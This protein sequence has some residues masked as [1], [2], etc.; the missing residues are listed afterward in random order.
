MDYKTF[1]FM[2]LV[3]SVSACGG[4]GGDGGTASPTPTVVI[5]SSAVADNV[6]MQATSAGTVSTDINNIVPLSIN[7]PS[8]SQTGFNPIDFT[9]QLLHLS[10][11]HLLQPLTVNSCSG[12]GSMTV[13]DNPNATSGTITFNNCNELG[14]TFNGSASFSLSGD[15]NANYSVSITYRNLTLSNGVNMATLNASMNM[16]GSYNSSTDTD[17]IN[18][19]YSNFKFTVNADYISLYN[20]K[21]TGVYNNTTLAYTASLDY[22]FDSSLINGV[23]HVTTENT[24]QGNDNISQYPSSGSLLITG[25]SNTSVR[26]T[27]NSITNVTVAADLNGDGNYEYSRTMLWTDFDNPSLVF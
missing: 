22:T 15:P 1:L 21:F 26:V 5:N 11:S 13:P 20:Y 8:Q 6:A 9:R 17:T 19:T 4:G 2:G 12:G 18:V 3:L 27:I 24:I 23:V 7:Q 16:N 10:H 14:Y 25:A